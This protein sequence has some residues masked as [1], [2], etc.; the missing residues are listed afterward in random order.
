[1]CGF[2]E[3]MRRALE[4]RALEYADIPLALR[5]PDEEGAKR[6]T[7]LP[8]A[9]A[10]AT[11]AKTPLS[12]EQRAA[13][14]YALIGRALRERQDITSAIIEV[15]GS[16]DPG[17]HPWTM[18][19]KL[20]VPVNKWLEAHGRKKPATKKSIY[21]ALKEELPGLGGRRNKLPTRDLR[22][23]VGARDWRR[24]RTGLS[25]WRCTRKAPHAREIEG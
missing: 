4:Q 6:L 5:E 1:V 22:A 17:E 18:A 7:Q 3:S 25:A 23:G 12:V 14:L 11:D 15:R 2:S 19:G 13:Q 8:P 21:D 24:G 9:E 16:S 20:V 10:R